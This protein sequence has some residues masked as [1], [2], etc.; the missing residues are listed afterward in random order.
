M[1]ETDRRSLPPSARTWAEMDLICVV[2]KNEGRGREERENK[3]VIPAFPYYWCLG[4]AS[5]ERQVA[6]IPVEERYLLAE[7]QAE[8]EREQGDAWKNK[9]WKENDRSA[10]EWSGS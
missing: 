9:S 1:R 6:H 2:V 7:Q 5:S 3:L 4:L 10:F 8:R